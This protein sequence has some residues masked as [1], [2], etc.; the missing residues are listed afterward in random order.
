M[1]QPLVSVICL[2]Y[3]HERFVAEAIRSV[4]AQTYPNIQLIVVD[5]A[6]QDHSADVI[7]GIV[8][9]HP[10][11]T[12]LRQRHNAGNCKAFNCG[13]AQAKGELI[14]DLAADDILLPERIAKG[15]AFFE[16]AD[17]SVGVNFTDAAWIDEQ[18]EHLYHHSQRFPHHTV[19]QGDVYKDLIEKY[20]ICSPTMMFR[21]TVIDHLGGY[22]ETLAYEDFDFWIRSSRVFRYGYTPEVLVKKRIVKNS[23]SQNQFRSS[24]QQWSTF[25]VCEKIRALNTAPEEHQAL[26]RR[27]RYEM[28]LNLRNFNLV[29]ALR[30]LAS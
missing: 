23:L 30:Y 19:P 21:R 22:D 12:F 20:F 3:N 24:I 26:N 18:G 6:S 27:L 29:L 10:D 5:D 9:Q 4:Q 8:Q 2:C 7:A 11:I 1:P 15:I 17:A 14:I 13:L 28:I 16:K 25:K